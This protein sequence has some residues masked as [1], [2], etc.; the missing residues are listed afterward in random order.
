MV[1]LG[2]IHTGD[3]N[4]DIQITCQN[5]TTSDTNVAIDFSTDTA[6]YQIIVIDPDDNESTH[7]ASLLNSPGTDGII[8]FVNGDST[9]FDEA[10]VWGFKAKLTFDA[11][12]VF[13]TNPIFK[14]V[15]G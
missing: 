10:G 9:L 12:G 6:T 13:T 15:L 7:T 1:N 4:T 2:K 3:T 5:T 8:H 14:E 11:G